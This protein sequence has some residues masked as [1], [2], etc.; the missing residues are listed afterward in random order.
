[1]LIQEEVCRYI[2]DI[3]LELME[4]QLK[5]GTSILS[6]RIELTIIS[7]L[8]FNEDFTRKTL[9]FKRRIF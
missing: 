7:N 5:D 4:K 6:D 2:G 3:L 8:F 9:P 1:M